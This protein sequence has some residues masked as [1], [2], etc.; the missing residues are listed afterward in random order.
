[1]ARQQPDNTL[2][3]SR[4]HLAARF[5]TMD[6]SFAPPTAALPRTESHEAVWVPPAL[7]LELAD[8]DDELITDLVA[9]FTSDSGT[10]R[11]LMRQYL[12][13]GQRD[14]LKTQAHGLKGGASQVGLTEC[15]SLCQRL[16]HGALCASFPELSAWMAEVE[17]ELDRIIPAMQRYLAAE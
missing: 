12:A 3:C 16:E 14:Q 17:A 13:A 4:E 11:G 8:G 5:L 2:G 1:M 10:R 9:A 6:L 7:V 15:A